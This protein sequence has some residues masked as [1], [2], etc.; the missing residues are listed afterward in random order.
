MKYTFLVF[1]IILQQTTPNRKKKTES[2]E[3]M[4]TQTKQ[5]L[6]TFICNDAYFYRKVGETSRQTSLSETEYE[7]NKT[8]I[9]FTKISINELEHAILGL[10]Y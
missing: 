6:S 5:L 9:H 2:I 8:L 10:E 4:R 7:E 3:L 1:L